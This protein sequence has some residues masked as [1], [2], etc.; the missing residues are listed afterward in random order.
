[1]PPLGDGEPLAGGVGALLCSLQAVVATTITAAKIKGLTHRETGLDDWLIFIVFTLLWR[2]ARR[3]AIS[4]DDP[5]CETAG[6]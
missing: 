5:K 6:I 1:M 3:A 4:D 2:E